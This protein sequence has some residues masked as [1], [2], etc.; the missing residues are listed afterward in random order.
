MSA[1]DCA[2]TNWDLASAE[3]GVLIGEVSVPLTATVATEW[4]PGWRHLVVRCS[5]LGNIRE[6]PDSCQPLEAA[7]RCAISQPEARHRTS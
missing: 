1:L 5:R 3:A 2:R 6:V 7:G 4:P